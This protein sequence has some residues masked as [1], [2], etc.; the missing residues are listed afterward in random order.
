[1][2]ASVNGD[3]SERSFNALVKKVKPI[4]VSM[5]DKDMEKVEKRIKMASQYREY[6]LSNGKVVGSLI[7]GTVYKNENDD[8]D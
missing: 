6:I 4:L 1:V 3:G 2:D 5:Y 7:D 8:N